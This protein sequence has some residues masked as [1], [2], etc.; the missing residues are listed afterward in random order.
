MYASSHT[1]STE[2]AVASASAGDAPAQPTSAPASAGP[3][4][5]A[6]LRASSS[7]P[8]A[9]DSIVRGTS[10]GTSAGPATLNVSVPVAPM[11]P[12]IASQ[13][14]V[15]WPVAPSSTSANNDTARNASAATINRGRDIRSARMPAGIDNSRYGSVCAAVINPV[16]AGPA[17]SASTATIG[18]AARLICSA[19]W[20]ARFDQA[21]KTNGRGSA[22]STAETDEELIECM[23]GEL[24]PRVSPFSDMAPDLL[25]SPRSRDGLLAFQ[26]RSSREPGP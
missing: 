15:R 20:A 24:T 13:P 25:S 16:S 10:D 3:D 23:M 26:R 12:R 1:A 8:F 22:F 9:S 19:D 2:S 11:N 4:A 6:A 21:R 7:R 5:N 18:M 14:I 17:P